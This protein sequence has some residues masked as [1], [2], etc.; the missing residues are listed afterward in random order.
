LSAALLAKPAAAATP[1]SFLGGWGSRAYPVV[2]LTWEA[3]IISIAVCLIITLLVAWGALAKR[4]R[5]A[6]GPIGAEPVERRPG[7]MKW[8][9]WGVGLSVIPLVVTLIWTVSVLAAVNQPKGA[10]PFTIEV[11]GHQWWWEVRYRDADPS[12][13]FVTANEIHIPVGHPVR[14]E[15]KGADVIHSFWVPALAGKTDTIPGQTNVTWLEADRAGRYVGQCTE[16][17]GLQ[18]AH[19][20]VFVI[21]DPPAVFAHWWQSQLAAAA[22]PATVEAQQGQALFVTKCGSCHTVNGTMAQGKVAP[23][24]THLMSRATIA[25]G[26]APNTPAGLSGWIA[27]PQGV[28]PGTLMP[29]LYLSGPQLTQVR[30]YLET[31]K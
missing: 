25:A 3:L 15:L 28:K 16:Y 29:T 31:L 18:H 26:A 20:A 27:N 24:L 9:V 10:E 4:S 8:I 2:D 13:V 14:L 7:G 21:A 5:S 19:M 1:M 30:G 17:C 12:R 11:T 6:F 23:D 22:P